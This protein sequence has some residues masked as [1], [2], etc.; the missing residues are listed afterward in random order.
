MRGLWV[1]TSKTISLKTVLFCI[2]V[3]YTILL[4]IF[5]ANLLSHFSES[6]GFVVCSGVSGL[7]KFRG[8]SGSLPFR[9][10]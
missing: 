1:G 7:P 2:G 3:L 8:V 4:N 6:R 5:I 10:F 9:D